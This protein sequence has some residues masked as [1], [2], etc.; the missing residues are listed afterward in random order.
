LER[1]HHK[2]LLKLPTVVTPAFAAKGKS[3]HTATAGVKLWVPCSRVYSTHRVGVSCKAFALA[4][5][6]NTLDM[7]PELF[8]VVRYSTKECRA[9][10]ELEA[11]VRKSALVLKCLW[12]HVELDEE[13]ESCE[14]RR[15]SRKVHQNV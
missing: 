1:K 14:Q 9:D 2:A 3:I 11:I 6:K 15:A 7:G 4:I 10:V 12:F 8:S 5:T 13:R